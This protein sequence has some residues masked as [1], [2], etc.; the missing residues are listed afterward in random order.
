LTRYAFSDERGALRL[1]YAAPT[2]GSGYWYVQVFT[3]YGESLET[4]RENRS[5]IGI[6]FALNP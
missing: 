1:D 3:G 6:G 2:G 5:R 4:F